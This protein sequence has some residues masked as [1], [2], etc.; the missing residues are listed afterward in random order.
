MKQII[1]H[2]LLLVLFVIL[3]LSVYVACDTY[4]TL[5]DI[6]TSDVYADT[7]PLSILSKAIS[8]MTIFVSFALLEAFVFLAGVVIA[9]IN[10]KISSN[11]TVRIASK[12]FFVFYLLLDAVSIF[13]F[14]YLI[15]F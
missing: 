14:L 8:S 13:V 1:S 11:G 7:A 15:F 9:A 2:V 10:I 6:K 12:V 3:I 5:A 4:N